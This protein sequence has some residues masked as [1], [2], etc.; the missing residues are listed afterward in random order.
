M[1][2]KVLNN[3]LLKRLISKYEIKNWNFLDLD[4]CNINAFEKLFPYSFY[5]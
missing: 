1:C 5:F 4:S 3:N 2:F